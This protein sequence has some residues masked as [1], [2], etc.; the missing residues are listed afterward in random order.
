[1]CG[2]ECGR[3]WVVNDKFSF[4]HDG[5]NIL[6]GHLCGYSMLVDNQVQSQGERNLDWTH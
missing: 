1:M 2:C 4:K 3:G 5:I 6:L